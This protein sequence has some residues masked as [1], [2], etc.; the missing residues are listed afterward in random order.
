MEGKNCA[1]GRNGMGNPGDA[2]GV[3]G[4]SSRCVSCGKELTFN[5]IGATR[6]FVNRAAVSF[7]CRDCLA[8]RLGVDAAL[9]DR[10]IQEFKKQGCTLF[11]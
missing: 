8:E 5:E 1:P 3:P 4:A 6:K 10:K 7:Y 9:I 2:S 11:V